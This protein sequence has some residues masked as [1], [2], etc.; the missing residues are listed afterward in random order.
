MVVVGM[1]M[2]VR[3]AVFVAT[4]LAVGGL[5]RTTILVVGRVEAAAL[6]DHPDWLENPAQLAAAPAAAQLKVA[7]TGGTGVFLRRT[8]NMND[9]VRAWA[10]GTS[11]RVIGPDTIENGVTWKHVQDP[12]G[13]QGWIPS[14]YTAPA[15]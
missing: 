14:E 13:N 10:D 5:R 12:A 15:S 11:L 6:E 4:R 8:P 2:I 9:R 1:P 7:N 3:V